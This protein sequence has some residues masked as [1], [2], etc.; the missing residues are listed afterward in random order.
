[1]KVVEDAGVADAGAGR[2]C[3]YDAA[4]V[5]EGAAPVIYGALNS[6]NY[7]GSNGNANS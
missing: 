6:N 5:I 3:N 1:M 2:I 7:T 4:K